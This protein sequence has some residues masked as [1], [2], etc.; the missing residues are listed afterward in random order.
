[1]TLLNYLLN[2]ASDEMLVSCLEKSASGSALEELL[3][4][5]A[6]KRAQR[7]NFKYFMNKV[8]PAQEQSKADIKFKA[9]TL[10]DYQRTR[11]AMNDTVSAITPDKELQK[12]FTSPTTSVMSRPVNQPKNVEEVA[13]RV[14]TG[15]TM[16]HDNALASKA[17]LTGADVKA[18]DKT[19]AR[20]KKDKVL[21]KDLKKKIEGLL[22]DKSRLNERLTSASNSF[23]TEQAARNKLQGLYDDLLKQKNTLAGQL[24]D[25]TASLSKTTDSLA[26]TTKFGKSF[27]AHARKATMLRNLKHMRIAKALAGGAGAAGVAVGGG[28]ALVGS[29]LANK[30]SKGAMERTMD[31]LRSQLGEAQ[32]TIANLKKR[33]LWERIINVA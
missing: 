4:K 8:K 7:E 27:A 12:K 17:G 26:R 15:N 31:G 30:A 13:K 18:L 3:Y 32:D 2:N 14:A 22:Y 16:N 5:E 28:A 6:G 25:V 19:V 20:T 9:N 10:A 1:M 29:L 11:E 33:S 24:D 21:I 23:K